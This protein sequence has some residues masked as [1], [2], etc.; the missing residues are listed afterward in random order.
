MNLQGQLEAPAGNEAPP[1]RTAFTGKSA[2]ALLHWS[3]Q[4]RTVGSE[5]R[6]AVPPLPFI[7]VVVG[8]DLAHASRR[9]HITSGNDQ[10]GQNR[11][12]VVGCRVPC[13]RPFGG[14]RPA[15]AAAGGPQPALAPQC[16]A[17]QPGIQGS[18]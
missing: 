5:Q 18:P 9:C 13:C 16:V 6:R 3:T 8:A 11:Q 2:F 4:S 10:R 14:R 12:G 7:A 15:L 1:G 17:A